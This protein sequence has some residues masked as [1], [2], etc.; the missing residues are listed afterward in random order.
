MAT[1]AGLQSFVY[2]QGN[3]I[4][5]TATMPRR[6]SSCFRGYSGSLKVAQ[7]NWRCC[8]GAQMDATRF[9]R[10]TIEP[11]WSQSIQNVQ[12]SKFGPSF[13]NIRELFPLF[14]HQAYGRLI[15]WHF[16]QVT[17]RVKLQTC[18]N[19]GCGTNACRTSLGFAMARFC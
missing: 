14:F 1:R 11:I 2:A 19:L 6:F 4:L 12:I 15:S 10:S 9:C 3:R 7:K 13:E 18:V 5:S 16:S 17:H 8:R